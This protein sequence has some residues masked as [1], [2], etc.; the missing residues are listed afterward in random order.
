[1]REERVL[2]VIDV[3]TSGSC[4]RAVACGWLAAVLALAVAAGPGLV[5]PA[6]RSAPPAAAAC[7][8]GPITI[9]GQPAEVFCGPARASV[10]VG[11]KTLRFVGGRCTRAF[12]ELIVNIGTLI[13]ARSTVQRQPY[14]GASLPLKPGG[15]GSKPPT[16]SWA[17]GRSHGASPLLAL[18][19]PLVRYTLTNGLR[20]GIFS[21]V[22]YPGKQRFSGAF[23]C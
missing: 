21:G 13:L 12:S 4:S 11:G 6:A 14:F 8:A 18:Q 19:G 16:V 3:S 15:K 20:G 22:T 10:R 1:V 17:S 5:P 7:K 23:S 9:G 2:A